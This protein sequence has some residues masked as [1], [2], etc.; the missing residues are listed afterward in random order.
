[1]Y[2]FHHAQLS[3]DGSELCVARDKIVFTLGQLT[4]NIWM[5][6]LRK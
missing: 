6:T 3:L 4:G 1:V 2:H 5:T